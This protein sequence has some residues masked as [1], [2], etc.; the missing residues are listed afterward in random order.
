MSREAVVREAISWQGTPHMHAAR[1]KGAGVD[2]GTFLLEVF[3][4]V[5]LIEHVEPE[6][7]PFEF[8]LHR[9]EE[10]YLS[11]VERWAHRIEGT[12]EPGDL[13]LFRI[14]RCIS[15]GAIVI[16]WPTIIHAV[17]NKGVIF[18]DVVAEAELAHRLVGFW[19]V[20]G[21]SDGAR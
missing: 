20:F 21:G 6:A 7:L 11:H 2:C 15:H 14:G 17:V 8:H 9:S 12:P 1:V 4:R 18:G 5:G 19:S 13:A 3:E 16:S 10:V